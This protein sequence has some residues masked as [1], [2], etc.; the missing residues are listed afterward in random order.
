[1]EKSLPDCTPF[2]EAFQ[3]HH[4]NRGALKIRKRSGTKEAWCTVFD[5]VCDGAWCQYSKCAD[6]KMTDG[7]K[8]RGRVVRAPTPEPVDEPWVDPSRIPEK[9]EKKLRSKL[10][11]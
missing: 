6:R 1:M 11:T 8:C 2:C 4:Q 10:K 9:Y 5:D 7:G 3:C